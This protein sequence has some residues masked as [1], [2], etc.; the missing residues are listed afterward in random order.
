VAVWFK[1]LSA[2]EGEEEGEVEEG[3]EKHFCDL[4]SEMNERCGLTNHNA[5]QRALLHI[6]S[7]RISSRSTKPR[8]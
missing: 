5:V 7:R 6:N 4:A 1:G 3:R 8:G 2:S